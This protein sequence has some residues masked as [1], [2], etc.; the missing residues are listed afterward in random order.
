MDAS[1]TKPVQ[2]CQTLFRYLAIL[3]VGLKFNRHKSSSGDFEEFSIYCEN[4][5]WLESGQIK[6]IVDGARQRRGL[7]SQFCIILRL[8]PSRLTRSFW[9]RVKRS[10]KEFG[11]QY[12]G[13]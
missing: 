3:K 1:L 12:F 11:L 6:P 13:L 9:V 4:G 2:R 10:P 8:T 7:L 5:E